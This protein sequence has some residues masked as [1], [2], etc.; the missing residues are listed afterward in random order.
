[1]E[2]RRPREVYPGPSQSG[3]SG[4]LNTAVLI[5]P[6]LE[7]ILEIDALDSGGTIFLLWLCYLNPFLSDLKSC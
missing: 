7:C 3:S 4:L 6:A 1:M 5:S 2:I